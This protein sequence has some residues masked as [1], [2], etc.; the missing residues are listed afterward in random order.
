M[1][2]L[3]SR[4]S[5]DAGQ[6]QEKRE[7]KGERGEAAAAGGGLFFSVQVVLLPAVRRGP[8][9]VLGAEMRMRPNHLQ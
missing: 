5:L 9:T 3:G 4:G 7:K 6:G 2:Q 8:N 1:T